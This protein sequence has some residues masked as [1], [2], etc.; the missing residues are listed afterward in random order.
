MEHFAQQVQ[1]NSVCSGHADII[2]AVIA[3]VILVAMPDAV[4]VAVPGPWEGVV[5]VAV[6]V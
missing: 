3:I 1:F 4:P 5:A 6:P 2:P